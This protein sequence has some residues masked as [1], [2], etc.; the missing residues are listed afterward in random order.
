MSDLVRVA[1]AACPEA[2]AWEQGEPYGEYNVE[3]YHADVKRVLYC[4]TA[5]HAVVRYAREQGYDLLISH[6]PYIPP[7]F[8]TLVMHT[9]LDCCEGGL[10]DIW[11]DHLK[12]AEPC[13]H[14]DGTL[15]WYGALP[16]PLEWGELLTQVQALSGGIIGETYTSLKTIKTVVIC[17]GLGGMVVDQ[18]L[19]SDAD[20]YILGQNMM[21]AKET[22]FRAVIEVG[23]T[24]SEWVGVK[25]WQEVLRG[26][27]V[28]LTP[29][30]LDSF[31]CEVHIQ[32]RGT[33]GNFRA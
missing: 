1:K 33:Y 16:K 7:D 8:P 31:G 19:R 13:Q 24:L 17:T 26:V 9:A 32:K 29:K 4:V 28:D 30:H 10:N 25:F 6:H 3:N 5:S 21:S 12:L 23:H 27:R 22:G 2:T 15:G 14:F 18:A 11:R 20:C